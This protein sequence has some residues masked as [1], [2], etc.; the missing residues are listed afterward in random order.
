VENMLAVG[1]VKRA[2]DGGHMVW[3]WGSKMHILGIYQDAHLD[4]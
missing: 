1:L 4:N 3:Q 2:N